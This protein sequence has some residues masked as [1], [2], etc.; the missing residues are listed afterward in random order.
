MLWGRCFARLAVLG[1]GGPA[2]HGASVPGASW[3]NALTAPSAGP[4][5]AARG[6][7]SSAVT[8]R[9]ILT[10]ADVTIA[11]EEPD[12]N[13]RLAPELM[14]HHAPAIRLVA[15]QIKFT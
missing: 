8:E 12:R 10:I 1:V 7:R 2:H 14:V 6:N 15:E 5:E 3:Q 4:A 9:V 11:A 13:L